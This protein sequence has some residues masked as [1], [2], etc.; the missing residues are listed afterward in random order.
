MKDKTLRINKIDM[1]AIADRLQT[2][3]KRRRYV[4]GKE[5]L[6]AHEAWFT[7]CDK[8]PES[9]GFVA[10][11]ETLASRIFIP[12]RIS[13]EINIKEDSEGC[14]VILSGAVMMADFN[15]A[16]PDPKPAV[17]ARLEDALVEIASML[18]K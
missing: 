8:K 13:I 4:Y 1:P 11:M 15:I 14:D 10:V 6:T 12:D 7:L 9:S 16:N 18:L 3:A 5:D 2:F 17:A